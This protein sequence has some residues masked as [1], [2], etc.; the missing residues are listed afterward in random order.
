MN[1]ELTAKLSEAERLLRARQGD[2]ALG[3]LLAAWA[4]LRAPELAA[5]IE[6]LS[7][8]L[9]AQ[10]PRTLGALRPGERHQRWLEQAAEADPVALPE[11]LEH[12]T[13]DNAVRSRERVLALA[14]RR[15]DPRIA[16]R[17]LDCIERPPY[18][19]A[20]K[21]WT[22]VHR[23]LPRHADPRVIRRLERATVALDTSMGER[24]ERMRER[25]IRRVRE[26]LAPLATQPEEAQAKQLARIAEAVEALAAASLDAEA[27]TRALLDAVHANPGA[28]EHRQIYADW[29]LSRG[30]PRGEF[31]ALQLAD[32][33]GRATRAH[34][35][36]ANA[37][38]REHGSAWIGK[39]GPALVQ[40]DR[41][42]WGGFLHAARVTSKAFELEAVADDPT[43]STVEVLLN[44]PLALLER[45]PLPALRELGLDAFLAPQLFATRRRGRPRWPGVETLRLE[46]QDSWRNLALDRDGNLSA[47]FLVGLARCLP[48][49]KLEHL[50][51][52]SELDIPTPQ[53]RS[54]LAGPLGQRLRSLEL[55][56]TNTDADALPGLVSVLERSCPALERA[57]LSPRPGKREG[58]SL[59]RAAGEWT[60]LALHLPSDGMHAHSRALRRVARDLAATRDLELDERR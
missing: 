15:P 38:L 54:M 28:L 22:Q 24:L 6:A 39:L 36:R 31:I 41:A 35:A 14:A 46:L 2:A 8:A 25:S 10:R 20:G 26:A 34:N 16:A 32:L 57:F 9:A 45:A 40:R 55:V 19:S 51:L 50:R 29:L 58:L 33:H 47:A 59:R 60:A 37:L 44:P 7:D 42:F 12:L 1:G 23:L 21:F 53:V 30:D 4:E 13:D 11:L 49:P 56:L 27:Q 5:Q 43:W 17:L 52:R 18:T 3:A 48:L